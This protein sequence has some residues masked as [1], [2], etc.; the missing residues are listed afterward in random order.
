LRYS[1]ECE[2]L[3]DEDDID[4]DKKGQSCSVGVGNVLLKLSNM[5]EV[6]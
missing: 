4:D 5:E 1:T 3:E 6:V 2:E